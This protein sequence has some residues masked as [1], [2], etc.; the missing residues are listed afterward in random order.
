MKK[1]K[2]KLLLCLLVCLSSYCQAQISLVKDLL[3]G[4]QSYTIPVITKT[5]E[6]IYISASSSDD[7]LIKTDGTSEGTMVIE[8][9]AP[10]QIGR[11]GNNIYFENYDVEGPS[12]FMSDGTP[13]GSAVASGSNSITEISQIYQAENKIYV[14]AYNEG[15]ISPVSYNGSKATLLDLDISYG[16]ILVIGDDLYVRDQDGSKNSLVAVKNN[17]P[18]E[19]APVN[20]FTLQ[21]A[22]E[23]GKIG[24]QP[25]YFAPINDGDGKFHTELWKVNTNSV[26]VIFSF[27]AMASVN[28]S[29]NIGSALF[30]QMSSLSGDLKST[31]WVSKG[32]AETT[33]QVDDDVLENSL[34]NSKDERDLLFYVKTNKSLWSYDASTNTKLKLADNLITA[35]DLDRVQDFYFKEGIA[36]FFKQSENGPQLWESDGTSAGTSYLADSELLDLNPSGISIVGEINK[37]LIFKASSKKYGTELFKYN[38]QPSSGAVRVV[39][40]DQGK[41]KNGTRVAPNRSNPENA[42]GNPQEN[43]TLNFVALGFG[44]SITLELGDMVY[45]DG[46]AEPDMILVETSY[47][48]ADQ[49]CFS[50]GKTYYPEQAFVEVSADGKEWYS[51]PN[52]NCRT[53]F[54][55]I[56][57]AV[58]AGMAYAKFIRITDASNGY[59]F[60]GAAD[61]F[62]VDGII[63]SRKEVE[64]TKGSLTNARISGSVASDLFD[65]NFMNLTPNEEVEGISTYPNPITE[66][67]LTIK[68]SMDAAQKGS[69]SIMDVLG[70]VKLSKE[71]SLNAG[72]NDLQIDMSTLEKGTYLIQFES[73]NRTENA[74]VI[75]R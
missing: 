58:D 65:P 57:P 47:G 75:T 3:P 4:N 34:Y 35:D 32:T 5:D 16:D 38:F 9:L 72:Q 53:S 7:K 49:M 44:G 20:N 17:V 73:G 15:A 45:D 28:S 46:S 19:I 54:L 13:Y 31:L 63:I 40:F 66:G 67:L 60:D 43:N 6:A 8:N 27:P 69:I 23:W 36:Y 55:D 68:L 21:Y 52:S 14:A 2:T 42:L 30:F 70:R 59:S 25:Y 24:N 74:K 33:M 37:A 1:S 11:I 48:R 51:L 12:L 29:G 50:E 41:K 26:D 22:K 62:D 10:L 56:K 64:G 61:G 71:V 18:N 39:S